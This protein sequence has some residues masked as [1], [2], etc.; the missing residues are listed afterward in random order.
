MIRESTMTKADKA[1]IFLVWFLGVSTLFA[2]VAMFGA[3]CLVMA[4]D[5]E[6]Y[7]ESCTRK[8]RRNDPCVVS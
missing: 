8:P 5:L 2:L 6:R 1:L 4:A 7:R 3:I